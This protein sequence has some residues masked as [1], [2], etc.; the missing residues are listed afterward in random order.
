MMHEPVTFVNAPLLAKERGISVEESKIS[1]S[2]DYVN[3]IEVRA[4]ARGE[5]V[6]VAGVLVGKDTERLVRLY[7][8][9]IDMAFSPVMAFLR[10]EDRPGVVGI[11]GGKLGDAGVNIA[12]MQVA[13]H[14][15]GGEALMGIAV[16]SPI[17]DDVLDA[18][19]DAAQLREAKLIVLE[20]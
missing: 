3:L 10:Y 18:I 17:P 9:D 5:T 15:Q 7:G 11:V 19:G 4:E 12:N 16:D 20:D 6:S 2:L 13:R 8:Y 14:D 1:Q